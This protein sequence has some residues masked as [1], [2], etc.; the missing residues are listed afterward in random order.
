[1]IHQLPD[2]TLKSGETMQLYR[3]EA[4]DDDWGPR[5][6]EWMY[7]RT[8][9]YTNLS[10][11]HNCA[12]ILEGRYAAVSH[13]VFFAG[14]LDGQIVGTSW[15]GAPKDTMDV[16]TY[17]RILTHEQQRR[18]GIAAVLC[19]LPVDEFRE[20]G[21]EAMYLGT[22]RTNPARFIYEGLGFE[23][24]NYIENAGTIMRLVFS[25]DAEAFE[26]DYYAP[27][28]PTGIRP[29][30]AGDLAR[31]EVLYN[32]PL[33]ACKDYRLGVFYNTPFEG[34]FFDILALREQR[35]DPCLAL[36]TGDE[37]LVGMAHTAPAPGSQMG[38]THVREV[39]FLVHPN[40]LTE[41]RG[42]LA[43]V[44]AASPA[45][46]LV[47]YCAEADKDKLKALEWSGFK[48]A[49]RLHGAA[50]SDTE[51]TDIIIYEMLR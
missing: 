23:H 17:G 11:H 1:M 43:S 6:V 14:L 9:A 13:D 38:Q 29:L 10:W 18:K 51:Q 19:A 31:A 48:P 5:L 28:Q 35:S 26:A 36:V 40:Y 12:A 33:W 7:I 22:G 20:V 42:L 44:V 24:Y 21:G 34:Q 16:A 27:G 3:I 8:P 37:H 25:G 45:E 50:R 49:G 30:H 15:Y 32:L 39:E 47:A 4:P 41:A 46:L 2:A